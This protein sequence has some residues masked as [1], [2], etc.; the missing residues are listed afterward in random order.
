MTSSAQA[1]RQA[2][3]SRDSETRALVEFINAGSTLDDW[4]PSSISVLG[5]NGVAGTWIPSA[6]V[7]EQSTSGDLALHLVDHRLAP[8][9]KAQ[10]RLGEG[11]EC[12]VTI[13]QLTGDPGPVTI[14][15]S[16]EVLT[17][18]VSLHLDR[19][20]LDVEFAD[21]SHEG[22]VT[23]VDQFAGQAAD[24]RIL[25]AGPLIGPREA[26]YTLRATRHGWNDQHSAFLNEFEKEFAE[27]IGAR[28]AMATSSCT[29]AL[30]LALLS[31]GIGPGDEVIVPETT[32]VATGAAVRYVGAT[33]VFADVDP[34][35][36][37]IRPDACR[38][39]ITPRTKALIPVHLYGYPAD[40]PELMS[41]AIEHGLRVIEDAAPA[42]GALVGDQPVGTFGDI[43]CFSFQ[44]A[45]MLVTGEGGMLVTNSRVLRDRAWKQQDHGRV[46]GSF[47]ID[48]LGRKYKMSNL[49]A[50][51][52][53]AQLESAETQI[54]KKQRI[55]A[56]YRESLA[57]V[58]GISFQTAQEGTTSICWMTSI[59][60]DPAYGE[61]PALARALGEQ[62]ID[63]RPV[64]PPISSYPIWGSATGEPG[65]VARGLGESAI[66]LPSG[67]RL[68]RASVE[69][70]SAAVIEHMAH[71]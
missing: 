32:W 10:V 63:T 18:W 46:P 47:W 1:S 28:H 12:R 21:T 52:G 44:G 24:E 70:V 22:V 42:I 54:A 30:H 25:T 20:L 6:M 29:G 66:N 48:E 67:V 64:F 8:L 9:A 16:V 13:T 37:T 38:A 23:R 65:A 51:L 59:R 14:K 68:S 2:A 50:A 15:A 53:L 49:T 11:E 36:W 71:G 62:G 4:V 34:N 40:M 5:P 43:G 7:G 33:P 35:T 19:H 56:W 69:R 45:K 61:A 27:Y 57:G 26:T 55:N 60:V 58:P 3:K 17:N 41:I 31:L 39:L